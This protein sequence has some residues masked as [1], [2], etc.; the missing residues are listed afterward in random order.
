MTIA[1]AITRNTP[2]PRALRESICQNAG[3]RINGFICACHAYPSIARNNT[4]RIAMTI[5]TNR[6]KPF[7]IDLM[8]S[9]FESLSESERLRRDLSDLYTLRQQTILFVNF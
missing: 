3:R 1:K 7:Q 2:S 8:L 9:D 4:I 6:T 5:A